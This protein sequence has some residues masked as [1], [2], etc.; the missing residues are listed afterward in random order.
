MVLPPSEMRILG[1]ACAVLL[2]SAA[3][4]FSQLGGLRGTVRDAD[5]GVP[6]SGATV[7]IDGPVQ[8]TARSDADGN[9]VFNGIPAGTY[10]ATAAADG[11]VRETVRDLVVRPGSLKDVSISLT[12]Q[13]Y[14]LDEYVVSPG[15]LIEDEEIE[16]L[17][18]QMST[19]NLVNI[20][21]ADFISQSGASDAGEALARQT[22]TSVVD[23]RFVVVRGLADRYNTVVL[24][25]ARVP[26]SD[27]D[28]RAVNVD[29]FPGSL[30]GSLITSK[31]FSPDIPGE[32]T[33]GS[34]NIVTKD[35][36]DED[37]IGFSTSRS[38]NT[39]AT[40]NPDFVTRPGPGL[41]L[42]G[43]NTNPDREISDFLA[44]SKFF[45]LPFVTKADREAI[46]EALA[47]YPSPGITTKTPP[48]N[49]S[50]G[51][52]MAKVFDI[53]GRRLGIFG[54][55]T[56]SRSYGFDPN[57]FESTVE[58]AGIGVSP[59]IVDILQLQESSE[60]LLAGMLLGAGYEIS[61]DD[62]LKLVYFANVAA[63]QSSFYGTGLTEAQ[64]AENFT[65]GDVTSEDEF[66]IREASIYTERVLSTLQLSGDHVFG[67]EGDAELNWVAAYSQSYQDEPDFSFA[68]Y[69]V[70]IGG[71][72]R[73][74]GIDLGNPAPGSPY[75][76]GWRRLDDDNY[77][78]RVSSD[79]PLFKDSN[80]ENEARLKLGGSFD[81]STREYRDDIFSYRTFSVLAFPS[82]T[83]PVFSS[84]D[85][86]NSVATTPG[87]FLADLAVGDVPPGLL[88]G[89]TDVSFTT[90]SNY[91]A[92]QSLFSGFTSVSTNLTENLEIIG[93]FR[94]EGTDI[95]I[96]T[97]LEGRDTSLDSLFPGE[98]GAP[99]S[100]NRV[101]VL[102]AISVTWDF[103]PDM[104]ARF[105]AS[106]T[107]ARPSFKELA[108]I[109][110]REPGTGR[111][112]T[113]NSDLEVSNI[114]NLDLGWEW[115]P[116][117][118]G[119][120]VAVYGFTKSIENPIEFARG[121]ADFFENQPAAQVYGVEFEVQ[122]GLG[123]LDAALEP[124]D[125]GI[126][127]ALIR[128]Q[129]FLDE[130][131]RRFRASAGLTPDRALQGAPE[132]IFNSNFTYDNKDWGLF[133]GLFLN[134][135]GDLLQQAGGLPGSGAAPD[136]LQRP[137]T[138]LNF[139]LSKELTERLKLTFRA[140]N[141][142]NAEIRREFST[143]E[144][145]RVTKSGIK[146]SL[147]LSGDW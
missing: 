9:F 63:E 78:L 27:P 45:N 34:I 51:A 13:V 6:V 132:Y 102:P 135:T 57:V 4:G 137:V 53:N 61:P 62:T 120:V 5:F 114:S 83:G 94:T 47:E 113:G 21:G 16:L 7:R 104:R 49:F 86:D 116:G 97:G 80:R 138:S 146:Y 134:V 20:I 130:E 131:S 70:D 76:R 71:F 69:T 127:Y 87:D 42:L 19:E 109:I 25:G 98:P 95:Q 73:R 126:N 79:L 23:S 10:S 125:V 142:T 28:R 96:T 92:N 38:Y 139:T 118:G 141:L 54:G 106:R 46:D 74:A 110:L 11:Y 30:I 31:T 50:F 103:A 67:E 36:P 101:D 85:P 107:L 77:F 43:S 18:V 58:S 37:F 44:T 112:F 90:S 115:F 123:F 64:G 24:N 8:E 65:G 32:S 22:G 59:T 26:S 88:S 99:V 128:S 41:D 1:L 48:P 147:G 33:G 40:G 82:Y 15:N 133:A 129:A 144:V 68:N 91:T 117:G 100:I 39:Q 84:F 56:Y 124:F 66:F 122:K 140:E 145:R 17:E 72:F 55:F 143:G 111:F 2:L 81:R 12:A 35:I 14:V 108:P 105:A 89:G 29:I 136:V 119:D 52:D 60:E 3:P 121:A 93:G 75:E